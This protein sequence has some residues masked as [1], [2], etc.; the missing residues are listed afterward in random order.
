MSPHQTVSSMRA[1][2]VSLLFAVVSPAGS[3][4][5]DTQQTLKYYRILSPLLWFFLVIDL[6]RKLQYNF[7]YLLF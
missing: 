2:T 7:Y 5:L 1:G 6:I 3:M 4:V